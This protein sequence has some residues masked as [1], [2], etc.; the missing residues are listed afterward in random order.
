M[1]EYLTEQEVLNMDTNYIIETKN[2]TKQYGSQKSVADLNIHVKRGRIYGL[3][4]RNGA[5]KTT[6]MKICV[7][8]LKADSGEVYIADREVL[9]K[10]RELRRK[11]GYVPDFFGVYDNLSAMEY[12]QFFAAA[13]GIWG[14]E[15]D[16]LCHELLE[17]VN[18]SD[19][20][21]AEVDGLSRGMKQRLCL[22]RALVHNPEVLFL[23][24]PASGLD[25]KARFELKEILKNLSSMGKTIIISSHILPELAEM[26]SSIGV[27]TKG[28]IVLNGSIEE[29]QH[30][31]K[32]NRPILVTV[33][34]AAEAA[35]HILKQL[36][37][38]YSLKTL[39]NKIEI[40]CAEGEE[41]EVLILR[42]LVEARIPVTSFMRKEGNLETLFIDIMQEGE[43]SA[44]EN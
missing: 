43:E 32:G 1:I 18:L 20:A 11:V 39:D 3:L 6:T 36:P 41:T 37:S 42:A 14:K 17:L 8:L 30:A 5:G 2:L 12:L 7:G 34:A 4:G 21:E 33:Q 15:A 24:E 27:I 44:N 25:P 29:I 9:S 40:S 16:L 26:C 22:A 13:Y 35:E 28:R 23:D 31:A 10:G 19:K 38:V